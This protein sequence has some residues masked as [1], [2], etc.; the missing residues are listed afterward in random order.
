LA[1]PPRGR[2]IGLAIQTKE[3]TVFRSMLTSIAGL[4]ALAALAAPSAV[5]AP[6]GGAVV[7]SRVVTTTESEAV[8]DAS[9]EPVLDSEGNPEYR[10]LTKTEG[11]LFAVREGRLNQLTEDPADTEPSFS[12]DGRAIIFARAGD[13]YTVRADGSGLRRITSGADLDSAPDVSP[14][15]RVVV[16][17]RRAAAGAPA[18]LYTVGADGG[19]AKPLAATADDEHEAS[20]SPDGRAIVYVRSAAE[21]GGGGG[22]DDLYSVRPGGG[23]RARLTRTARLDEFDPRFFAGG[24]V[25]SRGESGAEASAYADIYT[26]R[27]NGRKVKPLVA[28]AGS[29]Y[30]EDVTR[31]GRL[32]LFRRDRGL[33][34]KPIGPGR[35]RKLSELPDGSKTNAVFSS[36]GRRVAAFIEAEGREQLSSIDVATGSARELAEGFEPGEPSEGGGTST[37]GPVITWQPVRVARR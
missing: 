28:G 1:R 21:A 37:I 9:G 29:A 32:L 10:Q 24:I 6:H 22:V 30:V 2:T 23:V 33:W 36:D 17:E 4:L 7:F 19:A 27:R 15:G 8:K 25:F 14:N 34:V 35:A 5:A 3:E 18:D 20:F 13:L 26:M 12:P 11:G 31:A 16:F